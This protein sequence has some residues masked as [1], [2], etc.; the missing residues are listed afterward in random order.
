MLASASILI[1]RFVPLFLRKSLQFDDY[2]PLGIIYEYLFIYNF[3]WLFILLLLTRTRCN[4]I[5][6][7]SEAVLFNLDEVIFVQI[8]FKKSKMA[9]TW[10][11]EEYSIWIK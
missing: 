3:I 7:C 4:I 9:L 11:G 8:Q 6:V 2:L 5:V 10:D 1:F